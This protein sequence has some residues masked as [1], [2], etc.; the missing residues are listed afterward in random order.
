[1]TH[2][3]DEKHLNNMTEY[4]VGVVKLAFIVITLVFYYVSF[5]NNHLIYLTNW[6]LKEHVEC[7]VFAPY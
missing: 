2:Q 5:T 3:T 6:T 4:F 7:N 1:M